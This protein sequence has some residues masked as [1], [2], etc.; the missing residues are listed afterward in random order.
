MATAARSPSGTFSSEYDDL[1]LY[2]LVRVVAEFVSPYEPTL[3]TEKAWDAGRVPS[4]H[5]D[6]PSARAICARL[7]DRKG[8]SFPWPELLKL[9]FDP[10]RNITQTHAQRRA[11]DADYLTEDHVYYALRRV[12]GQ[13]KEKTLAPDAYARTR[14]ALIERD[15]RRRVHLLA[16]LLPTVGQIERVAGSWDAALAFTMHRCSRA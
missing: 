8:K 1:G 4:G 2:T 3:V 6:A 15:R 16:D 12:A 14:R 7:A 11:D 13:R 5:P 9:V 10:A